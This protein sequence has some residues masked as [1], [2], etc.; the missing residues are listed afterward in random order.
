MMTNILLDSHYYE[1]WKAHAELRESTKISQSSIL[2]QFGKYIESKGDDT[3]LNFERFYY[4]SFGNTEPI[5]EDFFD[6]YFTH[7]LDSGKSTQTM[8]STISCLKN[9]MQFL[10]DNNMIS[11]NCLRYYCN[12]YYKLRRQDKSLSIKECNILLSEALRRGLKYY[13]IILLMLRCGLRAKEICHLKHSSVQIDS[14]LIYVVEGQKTT[15][16]TVLIHPLLSEALRRY[17]SSDEWL[18]W[19]AMDGKHLFHIEGSPLSQSSLRKIIA[20]ISN[21]AGLR[22]VKPHDLRHTMPNLMY[23]EGASIHTIQ[24]QMRHERLE[25]T[26]HYM[27]PKYYELFR[28]DHLFG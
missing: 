4:D 22:E 15:K 16:D 27:A 1:F 23:E 6:E 7:L 20:D 2:K 3:L 8:Y 18:E 19:R 11:R 21:T 9:F 14:S 12:P 10:C 25:T 5:D 13:T 28:K 17:L 26:L 24:R